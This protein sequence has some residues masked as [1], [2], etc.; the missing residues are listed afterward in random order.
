LVDLLMAHPDLVARTQALVRVGER[1]WNLRLHNGAD[2]LLP[3]GQEAPAL[4]RLSELQARNALLDRPIV[5]V[6]MRMPD[7]LVVRQQPQPEQAAP[8]T[9][10]RRSGNTRG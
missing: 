2:V 5:L 7:R 9:P 6:D 8:V 10:P 1:R 4:Q 3:E